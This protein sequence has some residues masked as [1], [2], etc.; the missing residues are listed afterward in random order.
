MAKKKNKQRNNPSNTQRKKNEKRIS[1]SMRKKYGAM[2]ETDK[3]NRGS[4][5]YR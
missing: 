2:A 5:E 1:V 3:Y 4:P